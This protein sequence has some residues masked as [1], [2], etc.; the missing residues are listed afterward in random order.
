MLPY[1]RYYVEHGDRAGFETAL[2][3]YAT[4]LDELETTVRAV[5]D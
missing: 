4:L 5:F 3:R 1:L 2:E